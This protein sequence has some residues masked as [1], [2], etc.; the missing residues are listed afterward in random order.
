[1]IKIN[2][3]KRKKAGGGKS[4]KILG[5]DIGK[6]F[7]LDALKEFDWKASPFPRMILAGVLVYLVQ[8]QVDSMKLEKIQE[9]DGIIAAV[10]AEQ[11]EVAKKLATVRGFEPLKKQLEDDER[12]IQTKLDIINRLMENRDAPSRL[13][14]QL[15]SIL[16]PEAWIQSLAINDGKVSIEG[17]ATSYALVS[18]FMR[19]VTDSPMFSAVTLG[20]VNETQG[21]EGLKYQTFSLT[22]GTKGI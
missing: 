9:Q 22:A 8:M 7:E 14:R 17:G 12:N 11:A 5:F 19:G 21:V 20:Q 1:M 15:S 13:L 3:L 2:L 4:Q 6:G 10:E 18:D 16:P